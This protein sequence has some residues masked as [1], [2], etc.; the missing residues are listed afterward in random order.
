MLFKKASF[1]ISCTILIIGALFFLNIRS[2]L[3]PLST[4]ANKK[5][6]SNEN[7]KNL[8]LPNETITFQSFL[9]KN[10]DANTSPD[11]LY[12]F[13]DTW[14]Q[15]K[16]REVIRFILS[17]KETKFQFNTLILAVEIWHKNDPEELDRWFTKAKPNT[18]LTA[19]C[20]S[21]T[22]IPSTCILYAERIMDME[23]RNI[24]IRLQLKPWTIIDTEKAISWS[25]NNQRNFDH[26]G[27]DVY[28]YSIDIN[29]DTALSSLS[30]LNNIDASN[31]SKIADLINKKLYQLKNDIEIYANITATAILSLS[32]STFKDTLLISLAPTFFKFG[33][34]Y[35]NMILLESMSD[36]S[37]RDSLQHNFVTKLTQQKG[38]QA[39]LEYLEQSNTGNKKQPLITTVLMTWG[40]DDIYAAHEWLTS[41]HEA[42]I[43][44]K[45][46]LIQIAINQENIDIATALVESIKN[47]PEHIYETVEYDF[48][49]AKLMYKQNPNSAIEYLR[50]IT[51]LSN[52]E[53]DALVEHFI[54]Q[55][56]FN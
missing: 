40:Q 38:A 7:K 47:S 10:L 25:A 22:F 21:K 32:D 31:S 39:A 19:L 45:K 24:I 17:M 11:T 27:I 14:I 54:H 4:Q 26:F 30:V 29:F 55:Q 42:S 34:L 37:V 48:H 51:E 5:I 41:W 36:N 52:E 53:K 18:L 16:P 35:N 15:K 6:I 23:S 43:E 33:S 1:T 49:I 20:N 50:G 8:K 44:T 13:L 28:R 56:T 12:R 46:I 2:S 3:T 9:R